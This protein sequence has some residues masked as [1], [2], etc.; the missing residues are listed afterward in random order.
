VDTILPPYADFV[1]LEKKTLK[2]LHDYLSRWG[3]FSHSV[4]LVK[5]CWSTP[6]NSRFAFHNYWDTNYRNITCRVFIG[7]EVNKQNAGSK[8]ADMSYC[9]CIFEMVDKPVRVLRK[10]HFDYITERPDRRERHPRFHL[11]YC[12]GLPPAM[13]SL[14][15]TANLIAP[16]LPEIEGPRIFSTPITLG[17]LM[18][19]AFHEFPCDETEEIRNRGEWRNL[20]RENEKQVLVPFYQRCSQLAGNDR[21]SFSDKVYVWPKASTS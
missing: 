11:Q 13:K 15:V 20:V 9:I 5:Q 14:G 2:L 3:V 21:I 19:L 18:N 16:L 1:K 12:G 4:G 17:L 7:A 10:F 6:F 8:I